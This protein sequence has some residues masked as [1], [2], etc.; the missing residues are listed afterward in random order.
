MI[1]GATLHLRTGTL[2]GSLTGD[3]Y[4]LW[5]PP[6]RQAPPSASYKKI[7]VTEEIVYENGPKGE[8]RKTVQKENKTD[9]DVP[10]A[11]D[12]SK[13]NV[14]LQ[15]EQQRKGLMW[16]PT[17]VVDF[18]A[19]YEF[20]ND[21]ARA[22][23][24]SVRFPLS[25]GDGREQGGAAASLDGFAVVDARGIP[26]DFE[27]VGQSAVFVQHFERGERRE[28]GI[29]YRT[30]GTSSFRYL[31][32]QGTGRVHDVTIDIDTNFANVDF[33]TDTLSP[34][35]RRVT[36]QAFH[37]QWRFASLVS[38]AAVGIDL[39]QLLNPGPLAA[40][41]TFFAP[42][43]LLFFFFVVAILSQVRGHELHPMH[44]FLLSCAFFAFHLL[45]AY[46]VDRLAIVTSFAI[47]SAVSVF[48]VVSYARLFVGWKFA[49]REM[50]LAQLVYLVLFSYTFFWEGFTGLA[51][52]IGAI[53]TLF[54]VMQ[55]TGRTSWAQ[56]ER[57]REVTA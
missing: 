18:Q 57:R 9:I 1:L 25:G 10:V 33:P 22:Q 12:A 24:I 43:S 5:G 52:T 38:S 6:G 36:A 40:K 8:V 49:L 32:A 2:T 14:K 37:G 28:F 7:E 30:R 41:V 23:D 46:L 50:G 44:Y 4:T 21:K 35:T 39:P 53:V 26:V 31:M 11:L 47:A 13:V 51:I 17:Y 42:L 16:F 15:L 3:V 54:F 55:V 29:S 20:V 19:R 34:T 27:I 45:F 56:T 48:L